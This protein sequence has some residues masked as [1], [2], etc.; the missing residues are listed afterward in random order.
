M[1][2]QLLKRGMWLAR[3]EGEASLRPRGEGGAS[4]PP[5]LWGER[6]TN[7]HPHP[8]TPVGLGLVARRRNDALGRAAHG[9]LV[10]DFLVAHDHAEDFRDVDVLVGLQRTLC[11]RPKVSSLRPP[12]PAP[13]PP[14]LCPKSAPSVHAQRRA[15]SNSS[16]VRPASARTVRNCWSYPAIASACE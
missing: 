16:S 13:I 5:R 12:P 2:A 6:G 1:L 8:T 3:G 11:L 7:L 4:L 14:T 10:P 15:S 9:A